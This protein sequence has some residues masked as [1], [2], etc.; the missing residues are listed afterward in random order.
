MTCK[1]TPATLN[2]AAI[3]TASYFTSAPPSATTH[4]RGRRSRE[5]R[6]VLIFSSHTNASK[7]A[8][9]SHLYSINCDSLYN[10]LKTGTIKALVFTLMRTLSLQVP[11]YEQTNKN[12]P[13]VWV[14][15]LNM[16]SRPGAS[17]ADWIGSIPDTVAWRQRAPRHSLPERFIAS[18]ATAAPRAE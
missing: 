17:L 7:T 5:S 16:W 14:P 8:R 9:A 15:P 6:A 3:R 2:L 12:I 10:S 4:P 18:L 13:G 1:R 11:Y